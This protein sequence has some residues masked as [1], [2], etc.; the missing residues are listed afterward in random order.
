M[1]ADPAASPSTLSTR[2]LTA[3]IRTCSSFFSGASD[4]AR[5]ISPKARTVPSPSKSSSTKA[6]A[7]TMPS[8]P[9][10]TRDRR[11]RTALPMTKKAMPPAETANPAMMGKGS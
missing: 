1:A 10:T 9:V 11:A 6:A 3:L 2:P 7:P 5:Q 8:W 4:S